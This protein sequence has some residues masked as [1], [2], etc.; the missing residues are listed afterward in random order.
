MAKVAIVASVLSRH[1]AVTAAVRDT[2]AALEV[3]GHEISLFALRNDFRD[4]DAVIVT[5]AATLL[6]EPRFQAAQ[7]VLYH[8][9]IYSPL[10][11]AMIALQGQVPQIAV[12]HNITP[13]A[14]VDQSALPVIERSFRQMH[15]LRLVDRIWAVSETN[16]EALAANG[17]DMSKVEMIPL[18][19]ERPA[20]ARLAAK[21]RNPI[22]LLFVGRFVR[23]KGV[24]DLLIAFDR[25]HRPAAVPLRLRLVGNVDFSDP[26]YLADL[27]REIA[28][29]R[30]GASVELLGQVDD[31]RLARFYHRS[32]I[33]VIPSYHEGFCVPVIEG[34]RAGCIPIGYDAHN[35]PA[36]ANGLGR[37][38][39]TGDC[40]ALGTALTQVADDLAADA[41]LHLDGGPLS[42]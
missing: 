40:N 24:R 32:H 37:M 22:E 33:L 34:L 7:L 8:F 39:P 10:F 20:P 30:L 4:F 3:G 19:V 21:P 6:L 27:R 2:A 11:D 1:D 28:L 35:L 36:I 18:A 15:N 26:Q 14:L 41:P 38:V 42:R 13:A 16:A 9:A 5:D 31:T 25:A 23:S 12:F 17:F 29:R